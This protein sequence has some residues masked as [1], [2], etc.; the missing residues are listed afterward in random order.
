MTEQ[1]DEDGAEE[2]T[3]VATVSPVT[4]ISFLTDPKKHP[5]MKTLKLIQKEIPDAV[6]V[7]AET[8]LKEETDPKLKVEC[9]KTLVA[10]QKDIVDMQQKEFLQRLVNEVRKN[11][12]GNSAAQRMRNINNDD[13]EDDSPT[14]V[15]RPDIILDISNVNKL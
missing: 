14:P 15:Y 4:N 7:I 9:A 2:S 6:R 13:D 11:T 5:L 1:Y 10:F 12:G 3:E 8:M